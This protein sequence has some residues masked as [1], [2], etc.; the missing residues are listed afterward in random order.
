[1]DNGYEDKNLYLKW[2]ES[3]D[4]I[5]WVKSRVGQY[6]A[7]VSLGIKIGTLSA[8]QEKS[9]VFFWHDSLNLYE[10]CNTGDE[11]FLDL[12]Y[13]AMCGAQTFTVGNTGANRTHDI[14]SV[15]LL[16]AR[17]EEGDPGEVVV[18]IR[19]T[20]EEGP[21]GGDLIVGSTDGS[22]L[23]CRA[24]ES[25]WREITFP[26]SYELNAGNQ[27]ALVVSVPGGDEENAVYWLND[28][29][30]GYSGGYCYLSEDEG[31]SW[32]AGEPDLMFE[33]YGYSYM[34]WTNPYPSNGG[35]G[36][37]LSPIL[38]IC[39]SNGES[40]DTMNLTWY[41]N[42]SGSWVAFGTNSSVG[43][44]T[45]HQVF[46]NA[47]VNGQWWFWKVNVS[48]GYGFNESGVFKFYTG[49][50]SKI[51]NNGSTNISGYLFMRID[52]FNDSSELWEFV[53]DVICDTLPRNL[54]ISSPGSSD[55]Q[56][57]LDTVFN[58]L[59]NS[60]Y[61][62]LFTNYSDGTYRV[63]AAFCNPFGVPLICDDETVLEAW[64][65]FTVDTT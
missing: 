55:H 37:S 52:F 8:D 63:Y 22:T 13:G 7:P 44:G 32:E 11:T 41:S 18:S 12:I 28:N 19:E 9:T 33:E 35:T 65:E 2:N 29:N 15:K 50:Q 62:P 1:M 23:P 51:M 20:D 38:N 16:L 26:S 58:G 61:I 54:N 34:A 5:V 27:Y 36:V 53:F 43:K 4:Y 31:E 48:D 64:Y 24:G 47:S 14:T 57:G 17:T 3:L 25:E 60:S 10:R 39:I 46:S 6:N 56:L 42:S 49:G 21:V 40:E 30:A 45:Y 59:L